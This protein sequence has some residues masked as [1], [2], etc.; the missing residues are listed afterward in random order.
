MYGG[1]AFLRPFLADAPREVLEVGCGTGALARRLAAEHPGARITGIDLDPAR[2]AQAQA[3]AA[4]PNL[5]FERGDFGRLPAE[6][7]AFDLVFCR[8]VLA[9]VADPTPALRELARVTRPGGRV[10]AYDMVHEGIWFS[11]PRPAFARLLRAAVQALRDRGLEPSQGLHLAPAM[12]RAGLAE[13]RAEVVPH[14]A[15]AGDP[16]LED[17]RRNWLENLDGLAALLGPEGAA[18]ADEARAEIAIRR[19]D[20]FLVEV[21]V[22]AHG[23]TG[24]RASAAP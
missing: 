1:L 7:G 5:R 10:V 19:D 9:H 24:G 16:K 23:R 2:V 6:D 11:P 13:V 15:L 20:D 22:L 14:A 12:I 18:A 17:H 4:P 3:Q 8:F 21:T